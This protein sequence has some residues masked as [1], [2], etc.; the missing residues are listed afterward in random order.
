MKREVEHIAEIRME[1]FPCFTKY[2]H[3]VH[4]MMVGSRSYKLGSPHPRSAMD[5]DMTSAFVIAFEGRENN[6]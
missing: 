3:L 4:S 2:I 5:V 1:M 6:V